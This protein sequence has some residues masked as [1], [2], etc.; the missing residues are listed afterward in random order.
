MV[1]QC[2]SNILKTT[3]NNAA[4]SPRHAA[5]M[6]RSCKNNRT[7]TCT[8]FSQE[9]MLTNTASI[10]R[11]WLERPCTSVMHDRRGC[12]PQEER[13]VL[14]SVELLPHFLGKRNGSANPADCIS[15]KASAGRYE[16]PTHGG[17]HLKLLQSGTL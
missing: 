13:L 9:N 12:S 14:H 7:S 15:R 8:V 17:G 10:R 16:R 11:R 4:G 5:Q 3:T 2:T 1:P 6:I